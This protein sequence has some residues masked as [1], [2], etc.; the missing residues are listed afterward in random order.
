MADSS[1]RESLPSE[2]SLSQLPRLAIVAY[3][4]RCARRVLPLLCPEMWDIP[5]NAEHYKSQQ[6]LL[7][8]LFFA[9]SVACY[10][11]NFDSSLGMLASQSLQIAQ[12]LDNG[13]NANRADYTSAEA[14]FAIAYAAHAANDAFALDHNVTPA[15]MAFRA[16]HSSYLAT[17]SCGIAISE[18]F[19]KLVTLSRSHKL[20]DDSGV[21]PQLLGPLWPPGTEPEWVVTPIS[22]L[23]ERLVYIR[24]DELRQLPSRA[25]VAFAYRCAKRVQQL[26]NY[27]WKAMP[28]HFL[29]GVDD[30][31]RFAEATS[32]TGTPATYVVSGEIPRRFGSECGRNAAEAARQAALAARVIDEEH[33]DRA[34]L[35]NHGA[36]AALRS[37]AA[38]SAIE[39]QIDA[40]AP[41]VQ[42]ANLRDYQRLVQLAKEET[43]TN[44][45]PVDIDLLGPLWPPGTEPPWAK[46]A[47]PNEQV[48]PEK[49]E[50]T[51]RIPAGATQEEIDE[52]IA[53]LVAGASKMHQ[54]HGG[55]GLIVDAIDV[56]QHAPKGAGV[57]S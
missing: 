2:G 41:T 55:S 13:D 35:L 20:T 6:V 37:L 22:T 19:S 39:N 27:G 36:M 23:D 12:R 43:W 49:I 48:E 26:V 29:E 28:T 14:A 4:A 44:T 30:E 52:I 45:S 51:I 24:A 31:L 32:R 11:E 3:A 1:Q 40:G 54:S 7:N 10:P 17:H 25:I 18:D 42:M 38:V 33:K 16:A 34:N 47:E 46:P 53:N 15:R 5:G 9:E 8:A 57:L 21:D 50:L 56:F